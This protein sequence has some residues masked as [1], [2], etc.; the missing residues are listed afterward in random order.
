[1]L[2]HQK[3]VL[4]GVSFDKA[5]FKKE[6]IKSILWLTQNEVF[7]LKQWVIKTFSNNHNDVIQEVFDHG[8]DI[9]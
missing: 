1:M 8:F 5:L 6:L 7:L 9:A 4:Q 2:E 3:T